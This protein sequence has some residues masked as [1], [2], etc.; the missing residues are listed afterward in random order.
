MALSNPPLLV[1]CD[2]ATIRI[3]TQFTGHPSV[4]HTVQIQE[5]EQ[6][7]KRA[8][9]KRLWDN[10][11]WFRPKATTRDITEVA[12]KSFATLAARLRSRGCVLDKNSNIVS[13]TPVNS[14]EVVAH[15]LTQCLF[16]FFA[17][18]VDLLLVFKGCS[19]TNV[20][21]YYD[22]TECVR[23]NA[24]GLIW[25]G[26]T[27]GGLRDM[28][29][30]FTNFTS[31]TANQKQVISGGA[32]PTVSYVTPTQ[33]EIDAS[34]NSI[35]FVKAVNATSLCG[36]TAWRI[37]NQGELFS[38]VKTAAPNAPTIDAT[39]FPNT[40]VADYWASSMGVILPNARRIPMWFIFLM[41][42]KIMLTAGTTTRCV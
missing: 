22:K 6:P 10:P 23:D 25:E 4:V 27:I 14:P 16:C 15:F 30:L 3:H 2:R 29:G 13:G 18:D 33:A 31:T 40:D 35:G 8:L 11:E 5:L 26:K 28:S 21:E 20:A 12:A 17:D 19:A 1:V 39:W 42:P 41:A 38:L 34:T 32:L 36:S 24:T 7:E 37:P 9:L